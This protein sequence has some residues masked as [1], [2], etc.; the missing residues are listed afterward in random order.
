MSEHSYV[1]MDACC[2][3]EAVKS[4]ANIDLSAERHVEAWYIKKL[5]QA[6]RDREITVYTSVMSI[7]EAVHVGQMPVPEKIQTALDALLTSGQYVHLVQITPF[8]C[9]DARNLRWIDGLTLKG[10]DSVHLASAISRS[11]IEFL[12][13][14]G[15]FSR[16]ESHNHALSAKGI[17]VLAPSKG[18]CLP[19]KYLQGDMLDGMSPH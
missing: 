4:D 12:S 2:F 8:V 11:C 3:I 15:R 5:L 6:H 9:T 19:A 10:A 17:S 16:L 7:A 18:K 14:D 13:L 1:Y